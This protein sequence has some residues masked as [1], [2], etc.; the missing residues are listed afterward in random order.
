DPPRAIHL[1]LAAANRIPGDI[2]G[3]QAAAARI[4]RGALSHPRGHAL[5][6]DEEVE[7]VLGRGGDVDRR[8]VVS[9]GEHLDPALRPPKRSPDRPGA[10]PWSPRGLRGT[11]PRPS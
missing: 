2:H 9:H 8:G 6:G 7:Y 3:E 5:L 10:P 11:I 1:E 4:E